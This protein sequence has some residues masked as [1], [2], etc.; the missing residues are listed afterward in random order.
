VADE[1]DQI[2]E[3]E[4]RP[5]VCDVCGAA[6]MVH[7]WASPYWVVRCFAHKPTT[8]RGGQ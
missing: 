2:A 3:L 1:D 6:D 5:L 7:R 4:S 8:Y